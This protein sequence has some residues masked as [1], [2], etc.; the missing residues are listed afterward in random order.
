MFKFFNKK[1]RR[2]VELESKVAELQDKLDLIHSEMEEKVNESY[3]KGEHLLDQPFIPEYLLFDEHEQ[4]D[5]HDNII[6]RIYNRGEINIVRPI[7]S[8]SGRY[9]VM[10]DG[11]TLSHRI[12]F[13]NM[14]HAIVFFEC[15]GIKSIS[16][17]E[18]LD[19]SKK[20]SQQIK[21][22]LSLE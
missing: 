10:I 3:L 2:I 7:R 5:D 16:I 4:S 21:K 14:F 22:E 1:K 12:S 9:A 17:K 18:Y 19:Q 11:K 6:G 20:D 13:S 15:L 8:K